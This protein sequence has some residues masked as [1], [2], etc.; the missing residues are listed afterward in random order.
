MR[1][2]DLRRCLFKG[3]LCLELVQYDL[4][5]HQIN[6]KSHKVQLDHLKHVDHVSVLDLHVFAFTLEDLKRELLHKGY[7]ISGLGIDLLPHCKG[8]RNY[9]LHP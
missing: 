6:L 5:G 8:L 7:G 3:G 4:R 2:L 1:H 9:G